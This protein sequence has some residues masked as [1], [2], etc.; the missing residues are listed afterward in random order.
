LLDR[1]FLCQLARNLPDYWSP[2][3]KGIGRQF[4]RGFRHR[5]GN[6]GPQGRQ[7]QATRSVHRQQ[8]SGRHRHRCRCVRQS[9][10]VGYAVASGEQDK[11]WKRG[12]TDNSGHF[13]MWAFGAA[14]FWSAELKSPRLTSYPEGKDFLRFGQPVNELDWRATCEQDAWCCPIYAK[15][16]NGAGQSHRAL[17]RQSCSKSTA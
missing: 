11:V 9:R 7:V 5:L 8:A 14:G 3:S 10:G 17:L 12:A 15:F 4:L 1:P 16:Y 13:E 6:S 2:E